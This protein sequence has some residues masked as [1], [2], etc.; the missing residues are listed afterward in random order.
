MLDFG[1]D[2]DARDDL[3]DNENDLFSG[4]N[5][6][7]R[8]QTLPVQT[9]APAEKTA[10]PNPPHRV[11]KPPVLPQYSQPEKSPESG[12]IQS[13]LKGSPHFLHRKRKAEEFSDEDKMETSRILQAARTAAGLSLEDVERATQIRP[14]HLRALENGDYDALPRPVYVLAYLRKLCEL[15]DVSDDDE[16]LLIKPWRNIPCELPENLPASVQQDM[17]N[18]QRKV[19]HQIEVALLALGGIIVVGIIVLIV[20]L[21]VSYINKNSVPELTFD[22]N[23]LLE[24][25]DKPQ[26]KIP[27]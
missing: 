2:M 19:L 24:L 13:V 10:A 14:H 26:L 27:E 1:T 7:D 6:F 5:D 20:V 11:I 23:K 4:Q 16:E 17:E 21:I 18:P 22:N 15:Y 12:K 25:Q 9:P 8:T 3:A